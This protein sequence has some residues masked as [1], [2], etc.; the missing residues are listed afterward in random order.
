[1][2]MKDQSIIHTKM[3]SRKERIVVITIIISIFVF[4]LIPIYQASRM[5]EVTLTLRGIE[6]DKILLDEKEQLLKAY[7][8]KSSTV[9]VASQ[10]AMKKDLNIQKIPFSRAKLVVVKEDVE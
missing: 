8:A 4:L 10:N 9:D 2:M 6:K 1:M 7:L 5:R 3:I